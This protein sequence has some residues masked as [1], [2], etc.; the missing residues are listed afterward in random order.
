MWHESVASA[1]F[2][3]PSSSYMSTIVH[4]DSMDDSIFTTS[5]EEGDM[6]MDFDPS[7]TAVSRG[8]A[9]RRSRNKSSKTGNHLWE[10]VRDLLRDP[11]FNPRLLKWEDKENGVF[12]FVQSEQV[13]Q[14]WGEKK[15]NP[16]M[17][18]E[19]LSRA[20]RFCRK[21][22]FF[23]AVPRTGKFPKKLCF[24]FGDKAHGWKD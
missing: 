11:K 14:L 18:Y 5:L 13:A 20:M 7:V 19:K 4:S 6:E 17:T 9:P 23:N 21:T 15:N 22:G 8:R 2:E 12:R 1:N 16:H 3:D 10:F 24:M